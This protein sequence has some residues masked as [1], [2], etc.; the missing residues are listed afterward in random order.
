MLKGDYEGVNRLLAAGSDPDVL[1]E[2][3][4]PAICWAARL[5]SN[6][7][8]HLLI[9]YGAAVNAPSDSLP[10]AVP[11]ITHGSPDKLR[12]LLDAG[13]DPNAVYDGMPL[14]CWAAKGCEPAMIELLLARGADINAATED[15]NQALHL[16][17]RQPNAGAT[18]AALLRAGVD[19]DARSQYD[20]TPLELAA[21]YGRVQTVKALLEA[22][23]RVP[24]QLLDD[25]FW[26]R[27]ARQQ[28]SAD[29]RD[30]VLAIQ[31][32]VNATALARKLDSAMG[33]D[34]TPTPRR[35]ND[36]SP[37]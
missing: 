30:N 15:G 27:T 12:I 31:R 9:A 33:D 23:A 20:G 10:P 5:Q 35:S 32:L 1:G 4:T 25:E 28:T 2:S 29:K 11:A 21:R 18:I 8:L 14:L 26:E 34:S 36:P 22:G 13:A 19:V 37:L 16:A 24:Q 6:E 3:A 17:V 7:P